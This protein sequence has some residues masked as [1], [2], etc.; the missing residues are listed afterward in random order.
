MWQLSF[1]FFKILDD[2]GEDENNGSKVKQFKLDENVEGQEEGGRGE[3]GEV[4][5]SATLTTA[6]PPVISQ[7]ASD[8]TRGF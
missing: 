6:T 3:E 8:P 2:N 4:S 5:N 7:T 1:A